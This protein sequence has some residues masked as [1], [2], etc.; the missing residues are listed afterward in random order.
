MSEADKNDPM[1]QKLEGTPDFTVMG[2]RKCTDCLFALLLVTSWIATTV[3]GLIVIGAVESVYLEP[4]NP[5]R[6]IN[7]IDYE[8]R[9]CGSDDGVADLHKWYALPS[10]LGVCIESCPSEADSGAFICIDQVRDEVYPTT[11][12]GDYDVIAGTQYVASGECSPVLGSRD[13]L[14]YCVFTA[15][16]DA[17]S[18]AVADGAGVDGN[19]FENTS[20]WFEDLFGDLY[21]ARAYVAGIGIALPAVMGFVYLFFLRIPCVLSLMVWGVM[22]AVQALLLG[23]GAYMYLKSDEWS[24]ETEPKI[25]SNTQ[26]QG[27]EILSYVIIGFGCLYFLLMLWLRKRIKLAIGITKEAAKAVNAMPLIIGFPVMQSIGLLLF[28]V[29]WFVYCLYLASSGDITVVE[30]PGGI[31]VKHFQY[32]SNMKY[33]ALYMLFSYFWTSEF[34]VAIGQVVVAMSVAAWYFSRDKGKVGSLTVLKS[35]K[36]SFR[37]HLGTAAFGALIIAIIKTIR[38]V[39]AYFQ[40]KAKDTKNKLLQAVLCCVQCCLWC[41]EKCMKFLN[42]Q[43]YIQTA[44]FGYSFC[45]AAKKSFFLVARNI[46][47]VAAVGMVSEF[48]TLLGK[49]LIPSAAGFMFYAVVESQMGDEMHGLIGPTVVVILLALVVADMFCE[50][51]GM[52]ISTILQCFIADEEMF[53]DGERFASSGLVKTINNTNT[54]AMKGAKSVAQTAPEPAK[55]LP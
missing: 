48:V 53:K 12:G 3:L 10:R 47:R 27:M 54:Q 19:V 51:F 13:I 29:P 25:H 9:I 45:K 17:A 11:D 34:I 41:L 44:I 30:G 39:V 52:A 35:V 50:V 14:N 42:K 20:S 18:Q 38:A 28:L 46:L 8:G 40:K 22:G 36:R 55:E 23:G 37:Y 24:Q 33:A 5:Y 31:S 43:A 26:V 32:T 16:I 7:G 6:L 49:L 4:G 1:N 21:T 15:V 2:K